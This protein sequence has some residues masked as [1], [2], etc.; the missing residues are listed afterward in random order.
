MSHAF[1]TGSTRGIGRAIASALLDAGHLVTLTGRDAAA[2]ATAVSELGAAHRAGPR[3]AGQVSCPIRWEEVDTVQ[4]DEVT[5]DV[6][7]VKVESEGDP[8][9]AMNDQ[10]QSIDTLL[11][12]FQ[13][14]LDDGLMDA[15]WP[16]V[17]PKQPNEP[18]RLAPR[19]ARDPEAD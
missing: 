6:V 3:V 5:L 18:P 14:D 13:R 8:W 4:P 7:P 1:V 9:G 10:P 2:V 16:P 19:R 12:W 11:E 15:P 17:N